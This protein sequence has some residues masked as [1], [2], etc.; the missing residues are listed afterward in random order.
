MLKYYGHKCFEGL[1]YKCVKIYLCKSYISGL[2]GYVFLNVF[3]VEAYVASW[4]EI[5]KSL[6]STPL[7]A[8][9]AYVASWIEISIRAE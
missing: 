8:V 5:F 2:N 6:I 4:I 9:E 7:S 1:L 3:A